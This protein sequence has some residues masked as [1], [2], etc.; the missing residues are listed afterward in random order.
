VDL[1]LPLDPLGFPSEEELARRHRIRQCMAEGRAVDVCTRAKPICLRIL[2]TLVTL[3][4]QLVPAAEAEEAADKVKAEKRG[5]EWTPGTWWRQ[6]QQTPAE[7]RDHIE[8][9]KDSRDMPPSGMLCACIP[10]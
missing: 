8:R 3:A 6:L 7:V 1:G 10:L 9:I 4:G 2:P 5:Q